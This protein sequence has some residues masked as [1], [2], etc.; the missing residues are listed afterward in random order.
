MR[1]GIFGLVCCLICGQIATARAD[2]VADE[3]DLQFTVGAEAYSK[4]EFTS[5]LEHFLASNR[6]VSNRNVM[7]NIARAYEQLGRYPDAYRYYI[8]AT[9]DAPDGKLQK[10]VTT[11]LARISSRVAVI[12]VETTPPGATV[13][14][15]RRDLGS[16]GTSP[17]QLGLKA[18]SYTVIA[19]LPGYEPATVSAVQVATGQVERLK[20]DLVRI[21]GKVDLGGESGTRVRIDDE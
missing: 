4:G 5:A 17:S 18:G 1:S 9:R 7:F 21:L 20:L 3:A 14:L 12:A 13:Y 6:L 2:G 15:D 11:A 19:E 8:D 10:D 16:V